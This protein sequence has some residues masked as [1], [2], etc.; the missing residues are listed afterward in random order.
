MQKVKSPLLLWTGLIALCGYLFLAILDTDHEHSMVITS[1][2]TKAPLRSEPLH[3]A[4]ADDP[5]GSRDLD[6]QGLTV[7]KPDSMQIDPVQETNI[8]QRQLVE[9]DQQVS[10]AVEYID[11]LQ[12]SLSDS[13][14]SVRLQAVQILAEINHADSLS[15]LI[16]AL[17]D[18]QASIR[19]ASIE[20]LL[21]Q[22]DDIISISVE[23]LLYDPDKSV[24][25]SAIDA[26]G[27]LERPHSLYALAAL[28]GDHDADIRLAAVIALGE[29]GA[30]ETLLYLQHQLSDPDY[31]VRQ[32][33]QA[34]LQELDET[35]S[36]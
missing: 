13:N 14:P 15:L 12:S 5:A 8:S 2:Q 19:L 18:P 31:R 28:L 4:V 22:R 10:S 25:L 34:I 36:K 21:S 23:P 30:G 24:R 27:L 16:S 1:P 20:A 3:A 29:I 9:I 32:N 35:E 17:D 33:V 6:H 26:I 11:Y 7:P